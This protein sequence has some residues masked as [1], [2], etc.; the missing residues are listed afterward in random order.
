MDWIDSAV[1][2]TL[3]FLAP[4]FIAAWV[5]FALTAERKQTDL[6]RVIQALIFSIFVK[7][8]VESAESA[9]LHVGKLASFGYWS[10]RSDL[11]LSVVVALAFGAL[12]SWLVNTDRLYQ[13]LRR[14]G[15]TTQTSRPSVWYSAFR[16][17][18]DTYVVLQLSDGRRIQGWP[19]EWPSV[20]GD[21]HIKLEDPVWLD[22][23]DGRQTEIP[24]TGN[25]F[26][27]FSVVDVRWIE[28]QPNISDPQKLKKVPNEE[29]TSKANIAAAS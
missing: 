11:A 18:Q 22:I 12:L 1:F 15:L 10:N 4:G 21:G 6:Q 28:F 23:H 24:L 3:K 20:V 13:G 19:S 25:T 2:D 7:A 8:A 16:D 5:L 29:R 14:L 26:V 9:F 27:L 17:H